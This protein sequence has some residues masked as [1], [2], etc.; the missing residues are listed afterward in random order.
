MLSRLHRTDDTVTVEPV[1]WRSASA[2]PAGV[3]APPV[4]TAAELRAQAAQLQQQYEQRVRDAHAAGIREGEAAGRAAATAEV[5]PVIERLA[6]TIEEIAGLRG[7]LR[8]EAE[9]D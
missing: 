4:D 5:Q 3:P 2:A 1:V 6:R 7:R 8:A 9:A